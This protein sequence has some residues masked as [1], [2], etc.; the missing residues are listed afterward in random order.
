VDARAQIILGIFRV[1]AYAD[2]IPALFREAKELAARSGDPRVLAGLLQTYG[3][4][5]TLTDSRMQGIQVLEESLEYAKQTGD[6]EL[7]LSS[8][9][10]LA[11]A[12]TVSGHPRHALAHIERGLEL[13]AGD[14]DLGVGSLGYSPSLNL[15]SLQGWSYAQMGRLSE[16]T[17]ALERC[18]RKAR[19]RDEWFPLS[20]GHCMYVALCEFSGDAP[21]ALAHAREA[22]TWAEKTGNAPLRALAHT[23]LGNALALNERWEEAR[24]A[25]EHA[26]PLR[27]ASNRF[28]VADIIAGLARAYLELGEPDKA[29]RAAEEAVESADRSG[30]RGRIEG[31]LALAHILGRTAGAEATHEIETHL[32]RVIE[33]IE[34]TGARGYLPFAHLERAELARLHGD[35]EQHQRWLREAHRLFV[36]FG[37]TGHAERLAQELSP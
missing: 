23:N 3:F 32:E 12:H 15:L 7:E 14:L 33:L 20:F 21:A 18:V 5:L 36:E 16:A 17:P 25:Y 1:G 37:A 34:E 13:A 6:P 10:P 9:H 28:F 29:R 26:L 27:R 30:T 31:H 19:E 22:S 2:E 8:R 35:D 24:S 4:F 11:M